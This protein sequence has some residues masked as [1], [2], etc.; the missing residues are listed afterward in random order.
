MSG[1]IE[2]EGYEEDFIAEDIAR[3]FESWDTGKQVWKER[4]K[5]VVEFVY[6][7]S[8]RETSNNKNGWS[9]STHIPKLTQIYD[10]LGANYASALF[11]KR[12]FFTFEP[13]T[14]ADATAEK[15]KA[16]VNYL[17]TKHDYSGFIHAM[18][19]LLNDWVQTGNC[20]ANV[21]Y[22]RETAPDPLVPGGE[23]VIYEGPKVFRISPYDIVFDFTADE[24]SKTPKMFR[25]LINRGDFASYVLERPKAGFNEDMVAKVLEYQTSMSGYSDVDINKHNQRTMDGFDDYAAYLRS[26]KVE[27]LEFIGDIWDSTTNTLMKSR[28]ITVADRKFTVRNVA[29]EDLQGFGKIYHCGWRLR[30][31][32]LWAMGPLDNLVGMQYL[33]NHLENAR[34]DAFDQMLSP[35]RVHVGNV[36]VEQN[37][38]VTNYYIDDGQGSV[39][40]LAP[41]ATALQADF[42]IQVKEAQMEAYAGAPREAMGIRTAGEKTAFEVQQ[43]QNAAGRLFQVK[44]EDFEREMLEPILNGEIEVA[45]KNLNTSDVARV[46]DDDD[47][48][49]EFLTI[50][51]EDL[52]SRG[53][54]KARGASH[55]AKRAQLVQELQSFSQVLATDPDM[56]VHFPAKQRAKAW[57]DALNFDS[58]D[59]YSPFGGIDEMMELQKQQAAAQDAMA[60]TEAVELPPEV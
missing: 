5:E 3:R 59:L 25:K 58:L 53:K 48:V 27:L 8:T 10:N 37:G 47:G 2:I 39:T 21:E 42:Q 19:K 18:K 29:Q 38:P 33:I 60:Q 36:Q 52:T 45:V 26:G 35:D 24:F 32:N 44:I 50:T 7:T 20:F 15:R 54:L 56:K 11:S 6:A 12:E 31:D 57:N 46:I 4:V 9:H 30:P 1:S 43:L 28:V 22:V 34:A 13:S 55:F 40:N 49:M 17:K 23:I 16:I 51:R 14:A 41:D